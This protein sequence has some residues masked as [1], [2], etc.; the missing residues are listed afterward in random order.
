M[1]KHIIE[2]AIDSLQNLVQDCHD[3]IEAHDIGN[4]RGDIKNKMNQI[5]NIADKVLALL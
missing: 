3:L 4:A 5:K 1:S 2:E